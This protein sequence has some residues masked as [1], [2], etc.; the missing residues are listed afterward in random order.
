MNHEKTPKASFES[1]LYEKFGELMRFD[2]RFCKSVWAS[3]ANVVWVDEEG[4]EVAYSFRAAAKLIA[5]IRD[6][7]T[8]LDWYCCTD[9][10]VVDANLESTLGDYGWHWRIAR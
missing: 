8:Y 6:E 10:A 7:G 3:L 2:E 5:S 1:L 4:E 9:S